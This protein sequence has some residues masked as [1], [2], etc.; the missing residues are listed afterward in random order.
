FQRARIIGRRFKLVHVRFGREVIEVATYRAKPN[1]KTHRAPGGRSPV[2][3]SGRVVDDNV[4][5]TIEQDAARRDFT[6]NSLYYDPRSERVMDFLGGIKDTRKKTLRMVGDAR[7]RFT[8]DPVRMLRALRFRAKLGLELEASLVPAIADCRD[9]IAGVP[10]ARLYDEVLKMFH[11]GHALASWRE[12]RRH[13]LLGILFP[14]TTEAID[15]DDGDAVGRLIE[16]ALRNTDQ[17]V[18][19]DKPV[20]APFLFAV[21]LWRPFLRELVR[22]RK[23]SSRAGAP[24]FAAADAVF[25]RQASRVAVPRRVSDAVM[26]IWTMQYEL[27]ERDGDAAPRLMAQ[28]RFRAAYDFL[29][30]RQGIGEVDEAL[31]RWWTQAQEDA[32]VRDAPPR[33]RRD[34]A[35][36]GGASRRPRR[37]RRSR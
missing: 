13:H 24:G 5:G 36:G 30:L 9:A 27:E 6:I 7:E 10:A 23:S 29:L 3:T 22:A 4:F 31:T 15:G 19:A 2:A 16:M 21:L 18:R 11:H 20:I 32:P 14:L 37:G 26:E 34:E 12:L 33:A 25:A 1:A 35:D 28:R 17:R 8:E